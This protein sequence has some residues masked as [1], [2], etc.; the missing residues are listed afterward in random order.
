MGNAE[1]V[2]KYHRE[3]LYNVRAFE[4]KAPLQLTQ[5][6][7][8]SVSPM[9]WYNLVTTLCY[10]M[11]YSGIHSDMRRYYHLHCT[12]CGLSLIFPI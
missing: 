12:Q 11:F 4:H 6:C 10:D 5:N 8:Y 2:H 1:Y 9:Q 7:M 3:M